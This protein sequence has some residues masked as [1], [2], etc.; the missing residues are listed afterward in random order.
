VRYH[1]NDNFRGIYSVLHKNS[2]LFICTHLHCQVHHV[3]A[4]GTLQGFLIRAAGME[5]ATNGSVALGIRRVIQISIKACQMVQLIQSCAESQAR[6][7]GNA[8][9]IAPH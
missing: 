5:S 9:K 8:D 3:S 4:T 6:L 7:V 1:A 2:A